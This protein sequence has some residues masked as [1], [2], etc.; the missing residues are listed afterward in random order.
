MPIENNPLRQYFRRPAIYLKLPTGG[1]QYNSGIVDLPENGELPIFP[2]TALDEITIKTPD[3]LYSGQ[4]VVDIVKSCVPAIKD[5]WKLA[6]VDLDAVLIGIRTA[7][8][9][10]KQEIET[11]CPNCNESAKYDTNIVMALNSINTSAYNEKL[12]L[13]DLSIKFKSMS[14]KDLNEMNKKQFEM[15]RMFS[16]IDLLPTI[17][18]KTK[19]TQEIVTLVAKVAMDATAYSIEYIKTPDIQVDQTHFILD[20]V[21]NCDKQIFETIK[22]HNIKLKKMTEIKPMDIKCIH[23]EH[24]YEQPFTLN[25]TDFFG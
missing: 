12:L 20:F 3:A 13:G 24:E 25:A 19:K 6:S 7:T 21:K 17:E 14:Y 10:N 11:V 1:Q 18:E 16:Q 23:C 2:M 22:D 15:E 9:G 5:P 8:E 4:A